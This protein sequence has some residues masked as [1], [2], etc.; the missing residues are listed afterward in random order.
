MRK[1]VICTSLVLLILTLTSCIKVSI[2][3]SG[4]DTMTTVIEG[5]LEDGPAIVE[6]LENMYKDLADDNFYVDATSA[7]SKEVEAF[8]K[9]V[10]TAYLNDDFDILADM[11]DYPINYDS[12]GKIFCFN[13][14]K[15]EIKNAAEFKEVA[16]NLKFS[17]E[18]KKTMEEETCE[19][20]WVKP[21]IGIMLGDG[22]VW[23]ID[24]NFSGIEM[25]TIGEPEFKIISL[26]GLE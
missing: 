22:Q 9:K 4:V 20:I 5:N 24:K 7:S 18:N 19:K 8:A 11:I 14:S 13:N 10:K 1:N 2:N 23:F 3:T 26:S 12:E 21:S 15:K 16:K 6:S 25:K 17:N